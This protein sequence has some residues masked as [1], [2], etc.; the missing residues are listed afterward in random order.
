MADDED[1]PAARIAA[2]IRGRPKQAIV[3]VTVADLR[4]V[5]EPLA[6]RDPIAAIKVDSVA[7]QRE[8]AVVY[9]LAGDMAHV[10]EAA[11]A[12]PVRE[13]A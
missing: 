9:V 2:A 4:A 7:D 11:G 10:L 3:G 8:G 13:S 12:E 5:C 1:T 6:T